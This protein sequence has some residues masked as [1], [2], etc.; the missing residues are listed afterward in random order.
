MCDVIETWHVLAPAAIMRNPSQPTIPHGAGNL[1]QVGT[2]D[3][4]CIKCITPVF[5]HGNSHASGARNKVTNARTFPEAKPDSAKGK[6]DGKPR[7]YTQSMGHGM[8]RTHWLVRK[9]KNDFVKELALN[10]RTPVNY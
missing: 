2:C 7:V 9:G 6:G 3:D 8:G 5:N 4:L 1:V 10:S